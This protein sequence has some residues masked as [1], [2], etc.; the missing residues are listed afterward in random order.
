MLK[1]K[2][3]APADTLPDPNEK[4]NY[5]FLG[6]LMRHQIFPAR[7]WV[8][9]KSISGF[10]AQTACQ[11]KI[12]RP[13]NFHPNLTESAIFSIFFGFSILSV[14]LFIIEENILSV[15]IKIS[16]VRIFSLF[17]TLAA[18]FFSWIINYIMS[19]KKPAKIVN[20]TYTLRLFLIDLK[21]YWN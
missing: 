16:S 8:I 10:L 7:I 20:I 14:A 12:F 6:T 1:G 19:Y 11:G 15:Y 17:Q 21:K 5:I 13:I 3:Y 2:C 9:Q 18:I 4:N